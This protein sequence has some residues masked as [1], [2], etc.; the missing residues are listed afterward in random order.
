VS[1]SSELLTP[2]PLSTQWVCPPPAPKAGGYTLAGRW[3]VNI[4]EDAR[5]WINLFQ[6]KPSTVVHKGLQHTV[7]VES[8]LH[9]LFYFTFC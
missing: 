5:H 4:S 1:A 6:C 7:Q 9:S 2:S 3:G 8:Y